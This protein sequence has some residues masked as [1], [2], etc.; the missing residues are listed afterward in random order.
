MTILAL[1]VTSTVIFADPHESSV[2]ASSEHPDAYAEW[3]NSSTFTTTGTTVT[4]V[5]DQ[6]MNMDS[7]K[8]ETLTVDIYTERNED[9]P[10]L[11]VTLTETNVN[12][13]I[14]EGTIFFSETKKSLGNTLQVKDGDVVSVEYTYSQVPGS[15]K[16]ED[17][18]GVG[19]EKTIQNSQR[20]SGINNMGEGV[21]KY[22]NFAHDTSNLQNEENIKWLE[23]SYPA[24]GTGV[25]RVTD[26][27]MNLDPKAVDN[28]DVDVWS[29]S[30]LAG[31]DLTVT[32]T[33]VAT[34]I[35]E[36]TVFFSTDDESSG[37]RLR[38]A[39]GGAIIVKYGDSVLPDSYTTADDLD[40]ISTA[41]IQGIYNPDNAD[42]RITLDKTN[43]TWTDKVYITIDAPEHN[44][45][46]NKIEEIGTS[47]QYP[48]KVATRH[49]DLDNYKL[50]ETGTDTGIF[51]GEVILTGFAHD[52]DGSATTGVNG[53][54][55]EDIHPSGDGPVDG[56]LPSYD[57][58]GITVS[59]EHAEDQT[60][61]GSAYIK[62]NM[63]QVQWL[64][65]NYPST[66]TGVV[67]VIDPDMNLNPN[68]LDQFKIDV[69]SDSDAAGIDLTVTETNIS[70]GIFEGTVFFGTNWESLGHKLRI[71][72]GDS[73]TAKY[74][75]NTLPDSHTVSD[76]IDITA[77]TFVESDGNEY[78][79]DVHDLEEIFEEYCEM[80]LG[81][82]ND[83][84]ANYELEGYEETLTTICE[85]DNDDTYDVKREESFKLVFDTIEHLDMPKY[86]STSGLHD[87]F[88]NYCEMTLG[89]QN[90]IIATYILL[91]GYEDKLTTICEIP[92]ENVREDAFE[93]IIDT[94]GEQRSKGKLIQERE[95]EYRDRMIEK[96]HEEIT[97]KSQPELKTPKQQIVDG[98]SPNEIQCKKELQLILKS[99]DDSPACVKS[100]TA[101]KLL[102]RGWT[103]S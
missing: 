82:Q 91:E 30:D 58:D 87:V 5:V 45:D 69:W 97:K 70:T 36:G 54:D 98:I 44:F 19:Q 51:A 9:R 86:R 40:I 21:N 68:E 84:I 60:A 12:T 4:R 59:F 18:I 65:D 102:K 85:I 2:L 90:D 75:D 25:V 83:I 99:F 46:S 38:V 43:Y 72:E 88:E 3:D 79:S 62:W 11:K 29:D 93:D 41:S 100:S 48:V 55:V 28:F 74:E 101:E 52:A 50:V 16:L 33:N 32:E 7:N 94:L 53:N 17:M 61:I 89:E 76:V 80:T 81:E 77:N 92:G 47:E 64:E 78:Y 34:G 8:V 20:E 22:T 26:P 27:D 14:F 96:L 31:I 56:L 37:H 23:S 103:K 15:D 42:N 67:R 1:G 57:E 6:Y 10:E 66:G 35:F 95:L 49:F 73:I 13:G 63:G 71:T 39:E 24:T